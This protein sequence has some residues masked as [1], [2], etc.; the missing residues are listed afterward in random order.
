MNQ[1]FIES[2]ENKYP[3]LF[4]LKPQNIASNDNRL[5]LDSSHVLHSS[6]IKK[7]KIFLFV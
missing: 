3:K 5:D 2:P 6:S 7:Y 4:F 1:N